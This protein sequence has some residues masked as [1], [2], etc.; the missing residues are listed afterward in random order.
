MANYSRI[1]SDNSWVM[2]FILFLILSCSAEEPEGI[3]VSQFA[4][5]YSNIN[6]KKYIFKITEETLN[7]TP[8][9]SADKIIPLTASDAVKIAELEISNYSEEKGLW[10]LAGIE[11]RRFG[12]TDKWLYVI[13]FNKV[14]S[15]G[16]NIPTN[17][18]LRI[19]VLL[20]NQAI[21]GEKK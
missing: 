1:K 3:L 18:Y 10:H 13:E 12:L 8:D 14:R 4:A 7:G 21:K 6:G 5:S 15:H 17:D 20:N 11:L 19:P 16:S 2:V 9:W